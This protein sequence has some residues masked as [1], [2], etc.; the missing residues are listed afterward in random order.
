MKVI[1]EEKPAKSSR[2]RGRCVRSFYSTTPAEQL[3][4]A[5]APVC[6]DHRR[7]RPQLR[8]LAAREPR[9]RICAAVASDA[10]PGRIDHATAT[11]AGSRA[12]FG[13]GRGSFSETFVAPTASCGADRPL[14][15][16]HWRSPC[17]AFRAPSSLPPSLEASRRSGR[18][19]RQTP[20]LAAPSRRVSS[21]LRH[22][23]LCQRSFVL[24]RCRA[25]ACELHSAGVGRRPRVY[26]SLHG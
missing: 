24:F 25:S 8:R 11:P 2:G 6:L 12:H 13:G 16:A 1:H 9:V 19:A 4:A 7:R 18:P 5:A 21:R 20:A 15:H 26:R 23:T 14:R 22:W 17:S 3:T 10:F